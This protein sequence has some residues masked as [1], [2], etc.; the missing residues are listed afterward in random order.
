MH[1]SLKITF[2]ILT[3]HLACSFNFTI[4]LLDLC[5]VSTSYALFVGYGVHAMII[6]Q[7]FW[8]VLQEEAL[9]LLLFKSVL[10]LRLL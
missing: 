1:F 7:Q 2:V 8:L 9:Q 4:Y 6:V 10:R 5:Q 3:N